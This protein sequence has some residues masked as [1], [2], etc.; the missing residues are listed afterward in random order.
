MLFQ[1]AVKCL[2]I[3][4]K[5]IKCANSFV[6]ENMNFKVKTRQEVAEEYDITVKTLN[7]RLLQAGV[8]LP[9]G[10]IFPKT[11]LTIYEALGRPPYLK[12][13]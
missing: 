5:G 6:M 9:S 4:I 7:S 8:F 11:Q 3:C 1:K 10:C 13:S 12:I 2:I